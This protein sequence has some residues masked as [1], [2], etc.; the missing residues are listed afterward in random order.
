MSIPWLESMAIGVPVLD[1][2]HQRMLDLL[3]ST[4]AHVDDRN[5]DGAQGSMAEYID[6]LTT[7]CDREE[8]LMMQHRYH[9]TD[10]H[11]RSHQLAIAA[12][13]EVPAIIAATERHHEMRQVIFDMQ[14]HLIRR[15]LLDDGALA[16]Y[17]DYIG[18]RPED[19]A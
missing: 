17:L 5:I 3:N 9:R 1:V 7:H 18:L 13:K 15:I 2:E 10:D 4:Q 8:Q 16:V 12:A 19:I 14:N 6:L 11:V